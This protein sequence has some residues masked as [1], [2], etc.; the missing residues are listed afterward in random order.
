M[1]KATNLY[2]ALDLHIDATPEQIRAA[3]RR[4]AQ[5]HHPDKGGD[6]EEFKRVGRAYEILSDPEKRKAYDEGRLDADGGSEPTKE[7]LALAALRVIV[8]AELANGPGLLGRVRQYISGQISVLRAGQRSDQFAIRRN[9][10]IL[11]VLR[12]KGGK[13][14]FMETTLQEDIVARRASI[15]NTV[16]AIEVAEIAQTMLNAYEEEAEPLAR[17][18]AGLD[19]DGISFNSIWR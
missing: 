12:F 10:K 3:Y 5:E 11:K 2:A 18:I 17:G 6:E 7:E 1:A 14:N 15:E 8:K 16:K 4:K 9:E 19:G 13:V